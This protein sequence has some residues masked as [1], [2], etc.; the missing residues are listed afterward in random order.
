MEIVKVN[1]HLT[2]LVSNTGFFAR[3]DETATYD[4]EIYLGKYDKAEN[5]KDVTAEE[6]ARIDKAIEDKLKAEEEHEHEN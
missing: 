5:Y 2:K 1:E 6:K 4:G 3:V